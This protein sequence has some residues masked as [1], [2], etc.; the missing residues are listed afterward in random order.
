[1]NREQRIK[2]IALNAYI[3]SN[4]TGE[5]LIVLAKYRSRVTI[6]VDHS[7]IPKPDVLSEWIHLSPATSKMLSFLPS[8]SVVLLIGS[9]Y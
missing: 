8:A 6:P 3:V 7:Q 9:D 2:S 1:M 5:A 4:N